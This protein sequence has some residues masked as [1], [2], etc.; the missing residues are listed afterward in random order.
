M[1]HEDALN[2]DIAFVREAIRKME[3]QCGFPVI[4]FLW[5]VLIPIGFALPDFAPEWTGL[6]WLIAAPAGG[7]ASWL[8]GWISSRRRGYVDY[9]LGRRYGLHWAVMGLGFALAALPGIT[10]MVSGSVMG[11]YLLLLAGSGYLLAAVHHDGGLAPSGLIMLAGFTILVMIDRPYVWTMTGL[12]VSVAL[13][14]G[15]IRTYVT[16]DE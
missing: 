13:V 15:A 12:M 11:A 5:A 6:Y 3:R 9:K 14:L 10:G 7:V 4:Y 2:D 1:G 8:I 16:N